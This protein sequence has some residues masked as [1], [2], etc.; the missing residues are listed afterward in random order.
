ME[1][2]WNYEDEWFEETNVSRKIKSALE[3]TGY[4]ITKFCEDKKE[5]G[6]ECRTHL[7]TDPVSGRIQQAR[8]GPRCCW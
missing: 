2:E 1:I 7:K 5:R 3:S 8:A 4:R 6:Q